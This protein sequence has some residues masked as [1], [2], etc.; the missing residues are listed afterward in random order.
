MNRVAHD[1]VD[2][3]PVAVVP[4]VVVVDSLRGERIAT[5]RAKGHWLSTEEVAEKV[6]H[7]GP[8]ARRIDA[9]TSRGSSSQG[10]TDL[11]VVFDESEKVGHGVLLYGVPCGTSTR[12]FGVTVRDA[13][14]YT[15]GTA[16]LVAAK[17]GL[18]PATS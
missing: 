1:G 5:V 2:S 7:N 14:P 3:C 15:N 12:S 16:C 17:A 8:R 6:A 4:R 13:I 18:E 10:G 11:G 9:G